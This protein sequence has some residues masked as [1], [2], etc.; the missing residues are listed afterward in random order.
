MKLTVPALFSRAD[1]IIVDEIG[2]MECVSGVFVKAVKKILDGDTVVVATIAKRGSAL[3]EETKSRSD[4]R[5]YEVTPTNRTTLIDRILA[6][7]SSP[8][9]TAVSLP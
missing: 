9:I 7:Y 5:L 1:S 4:T 8:D 3:I 6:D 2:K